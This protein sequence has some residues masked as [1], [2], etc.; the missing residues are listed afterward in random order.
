MFSNRSGL[1]LKAEV[2]WGNH[3]LGD[4][5]LKAVFYLTRF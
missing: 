5:T 3:R 1:S 2:P 4:W